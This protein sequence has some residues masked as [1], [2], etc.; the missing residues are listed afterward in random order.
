MKNPIPAIWLA[1]ILG[2]AA[3]NQQGNATVSRINGI[4]IYIYSTPS[5]DYTVIDSGKILVT[6]S[7]SCNDSVNQAVKKAAK[8]NAQAVIFNLSTERWEAIE[9]N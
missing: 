7:G 5:K 9:F 8:V 6:I 2:I 1:A 3:T 4:E